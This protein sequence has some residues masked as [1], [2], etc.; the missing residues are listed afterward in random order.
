VTSEALDDSA[1]LEI[2]NDHLSIL[3][4]AGDKSIAFTDV[5]IGDEIEVSV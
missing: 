3:S 1:R 2:P 4:G 5:D